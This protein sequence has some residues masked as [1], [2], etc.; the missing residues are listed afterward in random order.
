ML[1]HTRSGALRSIN[2]TS[3]L[4]AGTRPVDSGGAK[5][6]P[7]WRVMGPR[8]QM[9]RTAAGVWRGCLGGRL[10]DDLG[11]ERLLVRSEMQ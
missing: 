7:P 9:A 8:F 2:T 1:S 6:R 11:I 3:S 5:L 4:H 10:E